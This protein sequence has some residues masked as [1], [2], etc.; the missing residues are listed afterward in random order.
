MA[1]S[2]EQNAM[3]RLLASGEQGYDDIAALMGLSVDEVRAKVVGALA[4]LQAEGK[5]APQVPPP[6][7]G[8]AQPAAEVTPPEPEPIPEPPAEEEPAA[9]PVVADS[10][11]PKA[12]SE[13]PA[14]KSAASTPKAAAAKPAAMPASPPPSGRT[15]SGGRTITLPS[16][17]RAWLLGGGVIGAIV[18]IVVVILLVS[19]GGGGNSSSTTSTEA[20]SPA[21]TNAAEEGKSETAANSKEPT[22]AELK[23][24][25]GSKAAGVATFG[26]VK[27]KLAL[28]IEAT[29]LEPTTSTDSYTVWLAQS[30]T[31]MLPLVSTTVKGSGKA[32][33][34]IAAEYEVP[35]EVLGYLANGTFD[36]IVITRTQNKQRDAAIKKA[37]EEK[38]TPAYTGEPVLRGTITGPIVGLEVREEEEKKEESGE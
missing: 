32:A 33:G 11:A 15:P 22:G 30:Q 17:R 16:G 6:L 24:V 31:K 19:G 14:P 12:A 27:K 26:R 25:D 1:L 18:V 23:A 8:G 28:A 10:V 7:A 21:G 4:Q 9:E 3:L 37:T 38:T 35:V 29:G 20:N 2:D 5:P 36:Q 34:D 13:P